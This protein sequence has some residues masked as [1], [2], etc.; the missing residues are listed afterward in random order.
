MLDKLIPNMVKSNMKVHTDQLYTFSWRIIVSCYY[1]LEES[2]PILIKINSHE[3]V[4][5]KY[6]SL[7]FDV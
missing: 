5:Q 2:Q 3:L 6:M 7:Q 1:Y 4:N